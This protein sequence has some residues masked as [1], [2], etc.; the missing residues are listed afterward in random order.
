M[1]SVRFTTAD[2]LELEC[3][4]RMPDGEPRGGAVI[5]HPLPTHGGSKDHP[6]LWAVRN[7]LAHRGFAVLGFNFRGVM[8]SEGQFDGGVGEVE[9]VRA[10]IRRLRQAAPGPTVV[11]GWSFG[12]NV[13]LR[14][15]VADRRVAALALVAIPLGDVGPVR[16]PPLPDRA[17][18]GRWRRPALLLAGSRD[19]FCPEPALRDLGGR[20]PTAEVVVVDGA[21]HF[22]S[23]REREAA[24][25]VGAF[26]ERAIGRRGDDP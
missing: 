8:R 17:T 25:R 9:D 22:F 19:R 21:D 2:G 12:A 15:A 13:A 5:C 23:G 18:L 10:A 14:E 20:I 11:A 26:A 1:E 4:I 6:L 7:D 3:D 24:E 16:L